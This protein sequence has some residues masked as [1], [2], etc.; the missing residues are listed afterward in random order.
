MK[1]HKWI[2]DIHIIMFFFCCYSED[3]HKNEIQFDFSIVWD[4]ITLVLLFFKWMKN[5]ID[6]FMVLW[7]H[8]IS[9]PT[10]MPV[11]CTVVQ[12][13]PEKE[14]K[15]SLNGLFTSFINNT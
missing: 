9:L 8:Y 11:S 1:L 6:F 14:K 2:A 3:T 12:S 13:L 4:K 5:I 10:N 7:R 15:T